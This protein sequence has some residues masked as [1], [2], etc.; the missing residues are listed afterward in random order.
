MKK[1]IDSSVLFLFHKQKGFLPMFDQ[2]YNSF[3]AEIPIFCKNKRS[4]YKN[5]NIRT[6]IPVNF[7]NSR[8]TINTSFNSTLKREMASTLKR[9]MAI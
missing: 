1:I 6:T 9:E 2:S 8:N 5:G 3:S 7:Y 4:D